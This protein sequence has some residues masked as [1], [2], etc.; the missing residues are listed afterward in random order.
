LQPTVGHSAHG[1]YRVQIQNRAVEVATAMRAYEYFL[2]TKFLLFVFIALLFSVDAEAQVVVDVSK[3]TCDQFATYK[4]ENPENIAI[5]L[6]GYYHGT[7][8]DMKV[9]IQTLSADAKKVE[10]YC[11]SK[12]EVPLVQAVKTVLGISIGP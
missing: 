5:W 7:R 8:G 9:D 1:Y 2:T 10:M 4:I 11:L 12:P 3:I 6:D